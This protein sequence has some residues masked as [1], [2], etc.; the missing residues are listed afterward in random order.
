V[1]YKVKIN[2]AALEQL[3][4]LFAVNRLDDV[5]ELHIIGARMTTEDTEEN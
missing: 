4:F 5:G 2:P 1:S 3:H